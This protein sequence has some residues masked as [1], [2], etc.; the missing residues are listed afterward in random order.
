MKY[1]VGDKIRMVKDEEKAKEGYEG[2]IKGVHCGYYSVEFPCFGPLDG[3]DCDGEVKSNNGHFISE[4]N[5]ILLDQPIAFQQKLD[6]FKREPIGFL[7]KSKEIAD[8]LVKVFEREGMEKNK[9]DIR[10]YLEEALRDANRY[11]GDA[12]VVYNSAQEATI[13]HGTS[14]FMGETNKSRELLD[15]TLE[16][17]KSYNAPQTLEDKLALFKAGTHVLHT[18]TQEIYDKLMVELEKR[19]Y[20]WTTG[21]NMTGRSFADE[22]EGRTDLCIQYNGFGDG[23]VSSGYLELRKAAG[24]EILTLTTEDFATPQVITITSDG[25]HRVT[26]ESNGVLA[27]ALCNPTDKF[28]IHKGS[29]MALKRLLEKLEEDTIEKLVDLS[30]STLEEPEG[31]HVGDIVEVV[32]CY[33][34][35]ADGAKGV[36]GVVVETGDNWCRV[37]LPVK[38]HDEVEWNF[39]DEQLKLV[40][41]YNA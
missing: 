26:A 3:H 25:Y 20:V 34:S 2:I 36:Q 27:E 32:R 38:F 13:T 35:F 16:E 17:L 5:I 24:L 28:S 19:G 8:E 10:R 7:V 1:K 37:K 33:Y 39:T 23:K 11:P 30:G 31:F 9:G 6:R 29:H 41:K 4:R 18:P 14:D 40:R 15:I 21:D 22:A 12:Y